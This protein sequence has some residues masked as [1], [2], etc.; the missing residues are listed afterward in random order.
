MDIVNRK[1]ERMPEFILSCNLLV[2]KYSRIT[3]L[4]LSGRR[5]S[6]QQVEHLA[7]SLRRLDMSNN[8]L[9]ELPEGLAHCRNL[10]HLDLSRNKLTQASLS[11]P[12][13]SLLT[14]SLSHN[15]L[16]QFPSLVTQQPRLASLDL[17]HNLVSELP[18]ALA[19]SGTL[20]HLDLSWNSLK[21]AHLPLWLSL[22]PLCK[23]IR[24]AG[25]SLPSSL[26]WT[27]NR[28]VKSL[29]LGNAGL[30]TL[31]SGLMALRD[32]RHLSLSNMETGLSDGNSLSIKATEQTRNSLMLLPTDISRWR[33]MVSLQLTATGLVGLPDSIG[34]MKNLVVLNISGNNITFLPG[35]LTNLSSLRILE[36]SSSKLLLLPPD[37]VN[38]IS[39]QHLLVAG[40]KLGFL[41]LLPPSLTTLDC[42]SNQVSSVSL[43]LL[44]LPRLIRCDLSNN[45]L[46]LGKMEEDVGIEL[47]TRYMI[48][49][50]DLRVWQGVTVEGYAVRKEGFRAMRKLLSEPEQ[51]ETKLGNK[52]IGSNWPSSNEEGMF[53]ADI[54]DY[55]DG[56]KESFEMKEEVEDGNNWRND[57]SVIETPAENWECESDLSPGCQQLY[58]LARMDKAQFWGEGQFCPADRHNTPTLQLLGERREENKRLERGGVL[59]GESNV[60]V[61][62]ME[63]HTMIEGQY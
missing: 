18:D 36:V 20:R 7:P 52:M 29:H 8:Q 44:S 49:Q 54:E 63:G 32:L 1:E 21:C 42:H 30:T 10:E 2:P 15:K 22:L 57:S 28:R 4:D 58:N 9:T 13:T 31:P 25:C 43:E 12:L 37:L 34:E 56:L 48:M 46:N 38:M 40:N 6:C 23:E 16:T 26:N 14:V 27:G 53:D 50:E 39:L 61:G 19:S 47:A 62:N 24:L 59:V 60:K 5:L 45:Y 3:E 35:T 41:P 33:D 55:W 11:F 17:S 51:D